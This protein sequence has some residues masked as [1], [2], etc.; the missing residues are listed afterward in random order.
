M[1]IAC[2]TDFAPLA[3]CIKDVVGVALV[4]VGRFV[5]AGDT[6]FDVPALADA[7]YEVECGTPISARF[8]VVVEAQGGN[9]LGAAAV[10]VD[11][12]FN[13]NGKVVLSV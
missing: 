7:L 10:E 8:A 2:R 9:Q 4:Q 11:M 6:A 13:V 5:G 1:R 3:A 12:V